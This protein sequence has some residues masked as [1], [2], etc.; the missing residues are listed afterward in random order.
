[1]IKVMPWL[2]KQ[3]ED[4]TVIGKSYDI[5]TSPRTSKF[6]E[7]EWAIDIKDIDE[8]VEIFKNTVHEFAYE[9]PEDERFYLSMPFEVRYIKA[10][11]GSLLGRHLG[12]QRHSYRLTYIESL[13][14]I[15]L[16]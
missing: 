6:V 9:R 1:M 10:D 5:M 12:E 3:L 14:A 4:E 8:A 11:T 15:T 2:L 13:M 7:G 16:F